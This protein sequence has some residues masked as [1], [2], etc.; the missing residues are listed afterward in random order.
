MGG[1]M[2]EVW[3]HLSGADERRRG[4]EIVR[5]KMPQVRGLSAETMAAV[6]AGEVEIVDDDPQAQVLDELAETGE[7]R[8]QHE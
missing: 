1:A 8:T 6:E 2:S 4:E 5:H 7:W 3:D